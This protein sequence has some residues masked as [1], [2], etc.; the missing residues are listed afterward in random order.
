M[1]TAKR[2]M[3]L[4]IVLCCFAI[5]AA[6]GGGG[7]GGAGVVGVTS[8]PP[9]GTVISAP[10]VSYIPSWGQSVPLYSSAP[11][12]E[13]PGV[14]PGQA[15]KW[16]LGMDFTLT[17]GGDDQFNDALTM[18]VYT[19]GTGSEL[20]PYDQTYGE[21]EFMTPLVNVSNGVK[22][23]AVSDG[24]DLV[25]PAISGTF[26]AYLN[27]TSDSRLMQ[28]LVLTGSTG[29]ITASW[30]DAV[31]ICDGGL[32]NIPGFTPSYRVVVRNSAGTELAEL[33]S[34][35][36]ATFIDPV[37]RSA[38][39]SAF[40]GQTVVLSF[41]QKSMHQSLQDDSVTIQDCYT[42]IDDV[43]V[44]DSAVS[45]REFVT[46][47]DF[48][49]DDLTGWTASTPSESQ[50]VTSGPRTVAG[51][52]VTRSFYT[53]PSKL[54]GR[55]V[56]LFTNGTGSAISAT[57]HYQTDL[58]SAGS[59]ILYEPTNAAGK[60][61]SAWDGA[62]GTRDVGLVFGN[63]SQVTYVSDDGI[64]NGNGSEY[65]DVYYDVTIPA[66]G[67][68]AIVNFIIMDGTDT[69]QLPT[70]FDVSARATEIDSEAEKIV[71]NF[72][73]DDQYRTGMTQE[74]INAIHNF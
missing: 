8:G 10:T 24:Q 28:S 35:A 34:S 45:P 22:T 52:D 60:A 6:C 64:G 38:D 55:W 29:A 67:K 57:I 13:T 7:G 66:G 72:R 40:A 43:S 56:D 41:E 21:L 4:V 49:T 20:F 5:L 53:V 25:Y 58:G 54:W 17:N 63:A 9:V 3:S 36:S 46:N 33:Y 62:F 47:G 69:N 32:Y 39:L 23:A 2:T 48:E 42:R 31:R 16:D 71:K 70:T 19:S 11:G 27:S 44:T 15:N 37:I 74:Q 14:F 30:N 12:A 26:S 73:S 59:G 61:L 68:V 51:L 1:E 18:E 50:N 65:V